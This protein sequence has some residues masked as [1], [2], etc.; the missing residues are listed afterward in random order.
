MPARLLKPHTRQ[1]NSGKELC[2]WFISLHPNAF[3]SL[4]K[5]DGLQTQ[6]SQIRTTFQPLLRSVF[7]TSQS[8]A[9]F[10]AILRCQYVEFVLGIRHLSGCPC[11]KQPSTK[12]ATC[13]FG[14]TKSGLPK[15]GYRRLH[16]VIPCCR[17]NSTITP[18]VER[19]PFDFTCPMIQ[20]RSCFVKVSITTN[21]NLHTCGGPNKASRIDPLPCDSR[22]PDHR[23][24]V[25]ACRA[26]QVNDRG[27]GEFCHPVHVQP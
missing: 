13:C 23:S 19:L 18:S 17:N 4:Y 5:V 2:D 14:K 27:K 1:A 15:S 16:P 7:V 6:S 21:A 24:S 11:Q 26:F 20:E 9:T 3:L 22:S 12:T 8:R 25:V 10:L